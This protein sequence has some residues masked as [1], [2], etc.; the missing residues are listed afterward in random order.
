MRTV[1]VI[2]ALVAV[3]A[4]EGVMAR[5]ST[6]CCGAF[7]PRAWVVRGPGGEYGLAEHGIPGLSTGLPDPGRTVVKIG[8]FGSLPLLHLGRRCLFGLLFAVVVLGLH[9]R[10]ASGGSAERRAARNSSKSSRHSPQI[11]R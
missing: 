3:L 1:L 2:A 6:F 4:L 5:R 7:R 11:D 10:Q 9:W 8:P